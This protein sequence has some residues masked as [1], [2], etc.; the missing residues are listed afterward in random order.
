LARIHVDFNCRED[1]GTVAILRPW[2]I[3]EGE[4]RVGSVVTLYEPGMECEA[5]LRHGERWEWVADILDGT[6]REVD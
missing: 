4:R 6:I 1:A 2:E 3:P 5:I